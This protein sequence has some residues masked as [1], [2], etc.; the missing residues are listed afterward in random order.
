MQKKRKKQPQRATNL[1]QQD[2]K[3]DEKY[4]QAINKTEELK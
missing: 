3:N 4:K 1:L 2:S